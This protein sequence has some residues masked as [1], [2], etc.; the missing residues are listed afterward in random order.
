MAAVAA[1]PGADEGVHPHTVLHNSLRKPV[2]AELKNGMTYNGVLVTADKWMNLVLRE[3]ICSA[4]AGDRFWSMPECCIRGSALR[5][6]RVVDEALV[7]R[8]KKGPEKRGL[9]KDDRQKKYGKTE[10][11][12]KKK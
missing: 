5:C 8:Q 6:V 3:V 9:T 12:V 4:A 10:G 7:A 11:F 1:A 2:S